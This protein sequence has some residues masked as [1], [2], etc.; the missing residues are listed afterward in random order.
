[1]RNIKTDIITLKRRDFKEKDKVIIVLSKEF[2]K[3]NLIA[4]GSQKMGSKLSGITEPFTY[5]RLLISSL[6][7]LAVISSGD[8]KESFPIIRS[9]L[10]RIS[11]TFYIME[12]TE[13]LSAMYQANEELFNT[14]LSTLYIMESKAVPE[15]CTSHFE[16]NLCNILGYKLIKDKCICGKTL[17]D[18]AYYSP[19][20]GSFL[21]PVC[22]ENQKT[23]AFPI[24]ILSYIT[25]LENTPANQIK[26]LIF[27]DAVMSDLNKLLKTHISYHMDTRLKSSDFLSTII[28][29]K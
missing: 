11:H 22:Q 23:I 28:N 6:K 7:D 25:A 2:G 19:Y 10:E 3:L 17:S 26:N 5:S 21:C 12:L 16:L 18:K 1:M 14:L 20:I 15:I 29:N 27:P 8:L 13:K 9:D 4:K 24:A